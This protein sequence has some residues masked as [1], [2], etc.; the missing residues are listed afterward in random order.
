MWPR[1]G[2]KIGNS[3]ICVATSKEDGKIEVVANKHGNRVSHAVLLMNGD[4]LEVGL[5]AK[6]KLTSKGM[7]SVVNNFQ[8]LAKNLLEDQLRDATGY[9]TCQYNIEE[10]KYELRNRPQPGDGADEPAEIGRISPYEVC[11]EFFKASFE[12]ARHCHILEEH[13]SVVLSIPIY[14]PPESWTTIAE[15]AEEAGFN[16]SQVIPEH[17][18]AL[19]AYNHLIERSASEK[20]VLCIKSGGLLTSVS[21]FNIENGLISLVGS[22]G[23]YYIGGK[24]FTDVLKD[25]ICTEFSKK[26]KLDPNESR[27]SIAKVQTAAEDCKHILTTLP[28]TQIYIDSLMDGVD[29]NIQMSRARYEMLI[30]PVLNE[31]MSTLNQAVESIL[32]RLDSQPTESFIDEIVIAGGT[33]KIP[34]IQS[35]I[36][37]RYPDAK[38]NSTHPPDEVVAMGCATQTLFIDPDKVDIDTRTESDAKCSCIQDDIYLWH[39]SNKS[40]Q[41]LVFEKGSLLPSETVIEIEKPEIDGENNLS[42]KNDDSSEPITENIKLSVQMGSSIGEI[43]LS[44]AKMGEGKVFKVRAIVEEMDGRPKMTLISA[45]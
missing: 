10:G 20:R 26:Y 34:K 40:K 16:V 22:A 37:A 39:N 15:A 1:F 12:L 3:T 9:L 45:V 29:F 8:F 11:M 4:E 25:F 30:Q 18:A 43:V 13:P 24:Q 42:T 27:R 6:Q 33:M 2:I 36:S 44:D 14:Y 17:T 5:T 28:S 23:P 31:F 7:C 41:Q 19:L 35:T 38:L 21:L 32:S